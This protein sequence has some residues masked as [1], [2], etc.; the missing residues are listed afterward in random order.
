LLVRVAARFC[1]PYIWYGKGEQKLIAGVVGDFELEAHVCYRRAVY[2]HVSMQ[3]AMWWLNNGKLC[4]REGSQRQ[5]LLVCGKDDIC[6]G[7]ALAQTTAS[8]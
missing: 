2:S 1:K 6:G 7:A 8:T 5:A 4:C 3:Y